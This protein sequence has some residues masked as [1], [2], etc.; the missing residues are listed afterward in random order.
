MK[1]VQLGCT[2]TL[3]TPPLLDEATTIDHTIHIDDDTN[4]KTN[5]NTTSTTSATNNAHSTTHTTPSTPTNTPTNTASIPF[6][7]SNLFLHTPSPSLLAIPKP[8]THKSPIVLI[9]PLTVDKN[10]LAMTH[11]TTSQTDP[12]I[13]RLTLPIT[14]KMLQLECVTR[15]PHS[16]FKTAKYERGGSRGTYRRQA[17]TFG[18][19]Y[20][21]L[22]VCILTEAN[23]FMVIRLTTF[24]QKPERLEPV[25]HISIPSPLYTPIFTTR[26][27]DFAEPSSTTPIGEAPF[28]SNQ[29]LSRFSHRFS[30]RFTHLIIAALPPQTSQSSP[31]PTSTT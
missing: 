2:I 3:Y 25:Y 24:T 30:H 15:P 17:P 6:M 7:R 19:H 18:E 20:P 9:H 27:Y 21:N 4:N 28:F 12:L 16:N 14:N 31:P 29:L 10:T 5:T 1:L 11:V 23:T 26:K 8:P 13:Q 22:H